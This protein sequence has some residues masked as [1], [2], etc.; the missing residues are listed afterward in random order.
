MTSSTSST[1]GSDPG[2][3]VGILPHVSKSRQG[4]ARSTIAGIR[5]IFFEMV[6]VPTIQ[7]N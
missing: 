3:N 6:T 5:L 1:I 7:L 4:S 2:F